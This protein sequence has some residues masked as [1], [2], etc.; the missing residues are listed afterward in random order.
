MMLSLPR[1]LVLVCALGVDARRVQSR[2]VGPQASALIQDVI[3][4]HE[5]STD[6]SSGWNPYYSFQSFFKAE[7]YS[8]EEIAQTQALFY[9]KGFFNKES[10]KTW[11]LRDH[12]QE[13]LDSTTNFANDNKDEVKQAISQ[14]GGNAADK[15]S[16][17]DDV[18]ANAENALAKKKANGG[19][20]LVQ[21][22]ST[23]TGQCIN[24]FAAL[25]EVANSVSA[26][27]ASVNYLSGLMNMMTGSV[28][29][30]TAA[31]AGL[32][33]AVASNTAAIGAVQGQV[34]LMSQVAAPTMALASSLGVSAGSVATL[35]LAGSFVG[36]LLGVI[37]I[38]IVAWPEE[39]MDPWMK[40]E[41]RVAQMISEK[42]DSVRRKRLGD[43]MRR[44]IRQFSQCAKAWVATSMVKKH[45]VA[46]PKWIV[47]DAK[48]AKE[49]GAF[50]STLGSRIA[51]LEHSDRYPA[52]PCMEELEGHMSLERDEWFGTESGQ[53][54]GLFMPFANMHTQMLSMLADHPYD[55]KMQWRP[56]L[57]ST[58]A[59]YGAYM[60][61]HVIGAWKAQVCRT[62]RLR[63]SLK[64]VIYYRYQWVVLKPQYQP[65]AAQS[66]TE[67]CGGKSGW[68][69]FCGGKNV[70]ACCKRGDT[71]D[72]PVCKKFDAPLDSGILT[73]SAYHVCVH[74][75]CIQS[76]MAYE[77]TALKTIDG[78][79][80]PIE[81]E[82]C[83]QICQD[84]AGAVAFSAGGHK[85]T[86][87][88]EEG[89]KRIKYIGYHSGPTVCGKPDDSVEAREEAFEVNVDEA[90]PNVPM[91]EVEP[92]DEKSPAES[93]FSQVEKK[94]LGWNHACLTNA[95]KVI[96]SEF[97]QFYKRI[98]R[99]VDSMAWMA[100]CGAQREL[101]WDQGGWHEV[102]KEFNGGSF[103]QC[104]WDR[105]E[106]MDAKMVHYQEDAER[107]RGWTGTSKVVMESMK[108][109]VAN[110]PM[111][112][113]LHDLR[114]QLKCLKDTAKGQV[115]AG[116]D[117]RST[118]VNTLMQPASMTT[119]DMASTSVRDQ[120]FDDAVR[121]APET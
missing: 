76:N 113:W 85:C 114:R 29:T 6:S 25:P 111:P 11:P 106:E 112:A 58:A 50:N 84:M 56:T 99:F 54:G 27:T 118:A 19:S 90:M 46:L 51:K 92:C 115:T 101:Q 66:C 73:S 61:E 57:K 62:M 75:D 60:L 48:T 5:Q 36:P 43:R 32:T 28:A 42:F 17:T 87:L 10:A 52:P 78:G 22:T 33:S 34:A 102:S 65:H 116:A 105:E 119:E 41:A 59:E 7:G 1:V 93:D 67:K 21:K 81:P 91:D 77:G 98:G 20:S 44:Y 109:A 4:A 53:V 64:N 24:P 69:D 68:C 95:T 79:G 45:G 3:Q 38:I 14:A 108:A 107:A 35:A 47:E 121:A 30:N 12:A 100:G 97:N 63:Q 8:K 31:V 88:K 70:G 110:Y 94:H 9:D 80:A 89:L 96:T 104:N 86:C 55:D 117:A 26:N 74:T 18:T 103:S 49:S 23:G 13:L 40:V 82:E 16:L 72:D 83:Q 37:A 120:A 2:R 15:A 71:S 39:E